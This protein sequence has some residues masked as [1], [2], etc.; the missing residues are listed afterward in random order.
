MPEDLQI[1]EYLVSLEN[2]LL[3]A[4]VRKSAEEIAQL[5]ADDYLEYGSSGKVYNKKDT[6]E[7]LQSEPV[8]E[9]SAHDFEVKLLTPEV[10]LV[11]YIAVKKDKTII[12]ASSLR[13]SLWKKT[14]ENWQ[15]VFHQGSKIQ[16]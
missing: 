6:I 5:L 8:I 4:A 7:A 15:I 2:K 13:S 12:D 10:A 11:R 3:S 16:K 14:G 1:K 9:I